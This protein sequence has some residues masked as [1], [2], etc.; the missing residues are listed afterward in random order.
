[1]RVDRLRLEDFRNYR[2]AAVDL[3]P[4]LNLVLGDN[5]QG[6]TNLLEAVYWLSGLGSPRSI[7]GAVVREEIGRASCRERV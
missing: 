5:A 7:D 2:A 4:G 6:K 1:L 3:A